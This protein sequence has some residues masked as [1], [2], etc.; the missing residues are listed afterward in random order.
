MTDEF[1]PLYPHRDGPLEP[2][3]SEAYDIARHL[4]SFFAEGGSL[5]D[6][7]NN[8]QET[9][10]PPTLD[11]LAAEFGIDAEDPTSWTGPT[12]A[13]LPG[14]VAAI[15]RFAQIGNPPP[16]LEYGSDNE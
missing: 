5:L 14:L 9:D 1:Q 7:E 16:M 13:E 3:E 4:Q 11:E 15:A 2:G 6:G 8:D 12:E 10:P